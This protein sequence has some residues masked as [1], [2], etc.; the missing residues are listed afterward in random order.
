MPEPGREKKLLRE[1]M[2]ALRRE[3][4][5]DERHAASASICKYA[6]GVCQS[7]L[8]GKPDPVIAAF[9]PIRGEAD[10]RPLMRWAWSQGYRV[11]VPKTD[12]VSRTMTLHPIS[13]FHE[14]EAGNWGIPEPKPDIPEVER[15]AIDM[16]F[17][18]G[19]A[20]DRCGRRL[21]YGGGYYDR[22]FRKWEHAA[23]DKPL[24]VGVAYH[25]QL[26]ERV[27]T[28][29]HDVRVDLVITESGVHQVQRFECS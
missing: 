29:P 25:D 13:G 19:L 27:P 22:F 4:S 21:G 2:G 26:I 7:W 18:P 16:I 1:R 15:A 20:F 23:E 14:L 11:A 28:E 17:V 10:L 8:A 12:K 3:M 5:A 6:E 24:T 9:V